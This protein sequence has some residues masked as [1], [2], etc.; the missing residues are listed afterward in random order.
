MYRGPKFGTKSQPNSSFPITKFLRLWYIQ[1]KSLTS[2]LFRPKTRKTQGHASGVI[3]PVAFLQRWCGL[4]GGVN[5]YA[6]VAGQDGGAAA[7]APG[8]RGR[9]SAAG[10]TAARAK[11]T[12]WTYPDN[13]NSWNYFDTDAL[14]HGLRIYS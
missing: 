3:S 2:P 7:A 9:A 5:P 14:P 6:P 12:T 4:C 11:R 8:G 1:T 10:G 13:Q